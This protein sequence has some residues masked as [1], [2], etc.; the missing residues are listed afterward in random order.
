MLPPKQLIREPHPRIPGWA[1]A[2]RPWA[3]AGW[4]WAAGAAAGWPWAAA[5]WPLILRHWPPFVSG[6][7]YKPPVT[8]YKAVL[9]P[10]INAI[11]PLVARNMA[12]HGH[13]QR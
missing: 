3:A 11:E 7:V 9:V 4:P 1:A 5:G 6:G 8:S 12:Q 13:K 2:G 10:L